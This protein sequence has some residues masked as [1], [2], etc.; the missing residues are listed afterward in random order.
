[1]KNLFLLFPHKLTLGSVDST[2]RRC[3][4]PFIHIPITFSQLIMLDILNFK[5]CLFILKNRYILAERAAAGFPG[6]IPE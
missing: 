6:Y 2:N 1:M 3:C 5:L 4:F